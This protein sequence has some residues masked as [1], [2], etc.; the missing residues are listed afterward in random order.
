MSAVL[1]QPSG[2]DNEF[3]IIQC[4][5]PKIDIGMSDLEGL[6]LNITVPSLGD[7]ESGLSQNLPVLV[8]IHGGG[9]MVESNGWPQYDLARL[10]FSDLQRSWANEDWRVSGLNPILSTF[11]I[12]G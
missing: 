2:C 4:S 1:S 7:G 10:D 3:G 6:H 5:L 11:A 9:F 8:F 12:D